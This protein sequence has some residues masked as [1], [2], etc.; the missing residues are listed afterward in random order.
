MY[1]LVNDLQTVSGSPFYQHVHTCESKNKL[2]VV[3]P[4]INVYTLV[5]H[6]QTVSGLPF[7]QH[8]ETGD[9]LTNCELFTRLSMC[10]H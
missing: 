5:N 4:F 6:L 2:C 8:V 10:T 1:T 3:H 7:Y 9:S